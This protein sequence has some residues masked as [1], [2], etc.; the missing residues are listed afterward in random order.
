MNQ[1][2]IGEVGG[3]GAGKEELWKAIC[4]ISRENEIFAYARYS[5]SVFLRKMLGNMDIVDGRDNITKLV[6]FLEAT[7]GEGDAMRRMLESVRGERPTLR[8]IDSIRMLADETFLRAES[9]NILLYIT[10]DQKIRYDRVKRRGDKPGEKE[11]TW[12]KFLEQEASLTEKH[13]PEIGSRADWEIENNGSLE[14]LEEK[15][16]EFFARVVRPMAERPE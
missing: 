9:H 16:R 15:V 5:T 12:E 14:E 2:V 7:R 1:V 11:L 6:T 8:I 10:A 3:Q 4:K 13:I